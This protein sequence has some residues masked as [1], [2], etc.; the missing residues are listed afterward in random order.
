V[1]ETTVLIQTHGLGVKFGGVR[2]VRDVDFDVS[3]GERRAVIGPNGAG[4][5][6]LFRLLTGEV[7]P[8]EG[9]IKVFDTDVTYASVSYRA[10]RGLGRT[11]QTPLVFDGLSVRNNLCLAI[12]G[13]KGHHFSLRKMSASVQDE[14]LE[15][16]KML[17]VDEFMDTLLADLSHGQR[18]Q[19]E[20]AMALGNKPKML[21]LDEP[22]AGLAAVER[23]HLT[24]TIQSLP[25]DIT[26]LIIEHDMDIALGLADKVTVMYEGQIVREGTP[27]VIRADDLVHEIYIGKSEAS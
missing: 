12:Q 22:A 11:F 9:S 21:L 23:Q 14:A 25:R 4:K 7:R 15:L 18:R 17:E 8:T 27:D 13:D 1:T 16:A 19:V 20:I 6:T 3:H 10:R 2:A 26:V 5:T 24:A